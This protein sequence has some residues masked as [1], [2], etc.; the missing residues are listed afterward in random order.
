MISKDEKIVISVNGKKQ[1]IPAHTSVSSLLAHFDMKP[2]FVAV[3]I[4]QDCVRRGTYALMMLRD[5]DKVE[6]LTPHAGG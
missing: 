5:G 4:N 1:I 3:A 2:E 6:I